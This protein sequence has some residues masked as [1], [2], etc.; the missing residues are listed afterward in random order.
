MVSNVSNIS[1]WFVL[2]IWKRI[3]EDIRNIGWERIIE[4]IKCLFFIS[5]PLSFRITVKILFLIDPNIS[6]D[7]FVDHL[8]L[9]TFVWL[10]IWFLHK[11]WACIYDSL[12]TQQIVSE[13]DM[14]DS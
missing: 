11:V 2:C 8:I 5:K 7:Q 14:F 1:K 10:L 9:Y 13:Y 6:K 4:D 3:Q 12:L